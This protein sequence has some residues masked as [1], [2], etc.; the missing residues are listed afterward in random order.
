[1]P[2]FMRI[3]AKVWSRPQASQPACPWASSW[4]ASHS[5]GLRRRAL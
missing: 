1:M 3:V 2:A 4:S 5:D